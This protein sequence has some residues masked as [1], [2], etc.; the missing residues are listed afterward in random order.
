MK[1]LLLILPIVALVFSGCPAPSPEP[2]PLPSPGSQEDTEQTGQV[3]SDGS[4]ESAAP[5]LPAPDLGEGTGETTQ[6][7][8]Q[9]QSDPAPTTTPTY[10]P[11]T[12]SLSAWCVQVFVSS[13]QQ[14]AESVAQRIRGM[15]SAPV[16][17]V[18]ESGRFNV[19][20]GRFSDRG[21]ADQIR[22]TLRGN[23]FTGAW[24]K[25]RAVAPTSTSE[26]T[27]QTSTPAA[28]S[29]PCYSVQ[30]FSSSAGRE[31]A[32]R[33]AAEVRGQTSMTV[34]VTQ[35]DGTW[36]VYVGRSATREEIDA[37]RDRLR[38]NGYPD[39]WTAHRTQ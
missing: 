19:Y 16:D 24:T 9:V 5:V 23:G 25:Q 33:V 4:S 27:T 3:T 20:A 8:P 32:E 29:G 36:K 37:E 7:T 14:G 10:E 17:V 31:N 39:A 34:E 18:E 30:V 13:T 35:V 26:P 11:P 1:R 12:G 21:P 2:G 6:T 22:D 28:V 15:V 38:G